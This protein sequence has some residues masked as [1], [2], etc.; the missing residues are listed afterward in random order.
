MACIQ[1]LSELGPGDK[2][3]YK[4]TYYLVVDSL[5][6]NYF[7]TAVVEDPG[8]VCALDLATYKVVAFNKYKEVEVIYYNGATSV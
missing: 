6:Y 4:D 2:F 5:P 3:C 7:L 1:S 8:L